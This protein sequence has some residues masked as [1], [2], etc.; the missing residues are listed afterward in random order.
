[1]DV[2]LN[3]RLVTKSSLM[4]LDVSFLNKVQIKVYWRENGISYYVWVSRAC[5]ERNR[6]SRNVVMWLETGIGF[7][8]GV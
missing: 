4:D 6:N 8:F 1:M 3:I 5:S 2:A 7:A